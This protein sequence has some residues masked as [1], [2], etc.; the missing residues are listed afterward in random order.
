MYMKRII[1]LIFLIATTISH[2]Q[3]KVAMSIDEPMDCKVLKGQAMTFLVDG[4]LQ[5]S[6]VVAREVGKLKS[7]GLDDYDVRFFGRIEALST[8]LKKLTKDKLIDRLTYADL[9]HGINDMKQT[10]NYGQLKKIAVVSQQLAETKASLRNWEKDVKLFY[11]L[12]ASQ[13]VI[14]RVYK[15]LRESPENEMTYQEILMK[16]KK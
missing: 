12:G 4:S 13:A 6:A 11:E 9:L 16:L 10:E 14:D 15:Y 1:F 7:C 3:N 8:L 5:S 2:A